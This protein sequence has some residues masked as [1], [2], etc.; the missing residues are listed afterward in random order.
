MVQVALPDAGLNL[1]ATQAVHSWPSGP[2]YPALHVQASA[3][4]LPTPE[5]EPSV[6]FAHAKDPNTALYVPCA[7]SVHV[8]L[9]WAPVLPA[10]HWQSSCVV[11]PSPP[12]FLP[13]GQSTQLREAEVSGLYFARAQSAH[14]SSPVDALRAN[15][16]P[17][18]HRTTV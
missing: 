11:A 8:A 17:G 3:T 7:H 12:E 4:T 13:R 2:V 5:S 18:P 9:P 6:Q 1:P 16:D 14:D 10:T 15:Y